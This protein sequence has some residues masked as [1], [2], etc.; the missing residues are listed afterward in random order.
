MRELPPD[1]QAEVEDFVDFLR[2][3]DA[4]RELVRASAKLSQHAFEQVWDNSEDADYD[5]L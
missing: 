4:E 2:L 5:R 1:K 3:R